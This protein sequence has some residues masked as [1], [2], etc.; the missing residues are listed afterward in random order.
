M[1]H[2]AIQIE[3]VRYISV[4]LV[5]L[6]VAACANK[7]VKPRIEDPE[8]TPT[9]VSVDLVSLE[10]KNGSKTYR[11]TTPLMEYYELAKEPFTEFKKGL[12]VETFDDTTHVVESDLVA[13]YARFDEKSQIWEV[14]GNVVG[15][16]FDEDKQLFTEQLFW[17]QKKDKIY[18]DKFAR[19]VDGK[20]VYRGTGFESDGKFKNWTF[21]STRGTL[22][23]AD[24]T[25]T[26]DQAA[27]DSTV[28]D[29]PKTN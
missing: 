17:D 11:M 10:S 4:I 20:G 1:Y 7:N 2:N 19:V 18:T 8:T 14:R 16:S 3:N 15:R 27:A 29:E 25:A 26:D 21:R 6:F 24:S 12:L 22:A 5:F 23:M 9:Q 28:V 13:D